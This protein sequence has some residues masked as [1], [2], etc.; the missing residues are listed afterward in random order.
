M[1]GAGYPE[2]MVVTGYPEGM[3]VTGYPEGMVTPKVWVAAL[4][5]FGGHAILI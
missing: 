1:S 2:G 4:D 3:V 5:Y